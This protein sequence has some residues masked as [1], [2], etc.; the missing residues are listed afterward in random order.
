MSS[1]SLRR[2]STC[3]RRR[4]RTSRS[5]SSPT[6]PSRRSDRPSRRR[7]LLYFSGRQL[8]D[9]CTLADYN[10]KG[11]ATLHV[12]QRTCGGGKRASDGAAAAAQRDLLRARMH[13]LGL[14]RPQ[15]CLRRRPD[16]RL[17]NRRRLRA[18]FYFLSCRGLDALR[19]ES[20]TKSS[21]F[22]HEILFSSFVST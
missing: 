13:R 17:G 9:G 7:R 21:L 10:I 5:D 6:R 4:A 15:D 18:L 14:C 12:A 19:H 16:R 8:Q 2:E 22:P 20:S 3:A 11:G 1:T